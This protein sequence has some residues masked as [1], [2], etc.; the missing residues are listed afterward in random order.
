[1]RMLW[2]K[3]YANQLS[4]F[5]IPYGYSIIDNFDLNDSN[6][7]KQI[8]TKPYLKTSYQTQVREILVLGR[9]YFL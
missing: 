4:V 8:F 3:Y 7:D 5:N 1:M 6:S 9:S 2:I